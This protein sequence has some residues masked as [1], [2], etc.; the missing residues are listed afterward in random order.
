M[1]YALILGLLLPGGCDPLTKEI[2]EAVQ[3]KTSRFELVNEAN[4]FYRKADHHNFKSSESYAWRN[5][6]ETAIVDLEVEPSCPNDITVR[7]RDAE[8]TLVFDDT[9][10]APHCGQGKK[11]W[12]PVATAAGVPGVWSVE[13]SFDLEGVKDLEIR[14]TGSGECEHEVY[15]GHGN[16]GVGNGEDPQPPGQPPVNDGPG[17]GPGAPGNQ[18]GPFVLWRHNHVRD[19]DVEETYYLRMSGTS[20]S[21]EAGWSSWTA[22][23]LRV[24]VKDEAG[25]VTYDRTLSG[26]EAPP[27]SDVGGHGTPGIWSVTFVSVD[28]DAR[29]LRVTVMGP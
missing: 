7:L 18:G 8:G 28:L 27:V 22:G 19:R 1:R 25:F 13:L 14:I 16:N 21:L 12:P 20:T 23:T 11:D 9:F 29:G 6:G 17:T 10:H 5:C 3:E 4:Y 15:V 26:V 2:L 24:I